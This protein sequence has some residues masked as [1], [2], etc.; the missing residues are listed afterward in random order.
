MMTL[1]ILLMAAVLFY[2]LSQRRDVKFSLKV[3]FANVVLESKEPGVR[4]VAPRPPD[5]VP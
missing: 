3:W 4:E 2:A 1:F 5:P